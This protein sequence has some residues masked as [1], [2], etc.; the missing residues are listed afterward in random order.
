[1]LR[2]GNAS[3]TREGCIEIYNFVPRRMSQLGT[4][5]LVSTACLILLEHCGITHVLFRNNS[6]RVYY[7]YYI[8]IDT[9]YSRAEEA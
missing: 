6:Q 2:Y 7:I 3:Q 5:I 9:V 8:N 4:I 1:M